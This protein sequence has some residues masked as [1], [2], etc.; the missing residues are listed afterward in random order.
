MKNNNKFIAF[1]LAIIIVFLNFFS[2]CTPVFAADHGGSGGTDHDSL[3]TEKE[4]VRAFI[5]EYFVDQRGFWVYAACQVGAF[6]KGDF[7]D[8]AEQYKSMEDYL[9]SEQDI[10]VYIDSEGNETGFYLSKEFMA[11]LKA[12]L[13]EYAKT[14]QTKE[15]NG[16]FY[17]LPTTK[18]DEV[19]ASYF[20]NSQQFRTFRNIV[21][22]KGVLAV[23][24]QYRGLPMRFVDPFSDPDHHILLVGNLSDMNLLQKYSWYPV[25]SSFFCAY[26]WKNEGFRTQTFPESDQIYTSVSDA[27]DYPYTNINDEYRSNA[28][29][30]FDVENH[31][32]I[33]EQAWILYSTTGERV[34]V[35]VSQNA[36]KNYS[37][38][39]RKI[40]FS[41]NYYSYVPD[42][43][44]VSIDDLQKSVDDLQ[45]I[46]DELLEKIGN[47]TSE[48]EIEELLRQILEE[49]RKNP[50][51]GGGGSGSGD[52]TVSVDLKET[53]SWLSKIYNRLGDILAKMSETAGQSMD[54]V[55]NSIGTSNGWLKKIAD[56]IEDLKN[57]LVKY[58]KT[59][60]SDLDDIK[61]QLE[62]MSEEEF[63]DKTDSFL[64][65][66]TGSFS[67]IGE[68]AKT[69]FPFS[70]PNDMK[71]FLAVLA[72]TSP[73]A[74]GL[75]SVESDG[76]SL[77]SGEH[78]GGGS[79]RPGSDGFIYV[80][81][82]GHGGGGVSRDPAE[83][84][85]GAPVFALPIV[86]ERY[87]IEEYVIIDMAPF[88]PV[89]KLSRS[90]FTMMFMLCLFNLTFKVM[91]LWGDLV[92][93]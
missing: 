9:N 93:D 57:T 67:E 33:S 27:V 78:G 75:Y 36:A 56:S 68:L 43:L 8:F 69:K 83:V 48:K 73:E 44:T 40:Y 22:E 90:L 46:I 13:E 79:S 85:N 41:E 17:L 84:V 86:L 30:N 3:Y 20:I 10:G 74:A 28:M 52:V 7:A 14:E 64:D 19:P 87:G 82:G 81:H 39:S 49:L 92:N 26:D 54:E 1:C 65:D 51:S 4:T 76:I 55:V 16:G 88:E 47:D 77:Y 70:I 35:F 21:I 34:R 37:V 6:V 18:F 89:S 72:Q 25:Y 42:D 66:A 58:L 2:V 61:D 91:G 32:N 12:L 50:G 23:L 15:E 24:T 63:N 29:I 59:I 80:E 38:G 5:K 62:D 31:G 11:Q 60:T 45:K 53:N 71:N